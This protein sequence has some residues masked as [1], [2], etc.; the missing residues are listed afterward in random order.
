[1]KKDT[2]NFQSVMPMSCIW[3]STVYDHKDG[4]GQ[5]GISS[6]VCPSCLAKGLGYFKAWTID[7]ASPEFAA[8][9]ATV[10]PIGRVH[11]FSQ[12]RTPLY[13]EAPKYKGDRRHEGSDSI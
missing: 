9:A 3:C 13:D 1:M 12:S 2:S 4:G 7:H 10:T 5:T 8:I 6:G 11:Q